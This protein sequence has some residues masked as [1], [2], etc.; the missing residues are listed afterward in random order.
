M[1]DRALPSR[2]AEF[3]AGSPVFRKAVP[4]YMG[5]L[6]AATHALRTQKNPLGF[7]PCG[8]DSHPRHTL[9]ERLEQNQTH[10]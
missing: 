3:P 9:D 8:F 7:G 6:I 10:S 5:E 2:E 1:P 4:K